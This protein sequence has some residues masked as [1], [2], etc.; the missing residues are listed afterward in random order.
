MPS[1]PGGKSGN[2][3][4]EL[5]QLDYRVLALCEYNLRNA[6]CCEENFEKKHVLYTLISYTKMLH[7]FGTGRPT[8]PIA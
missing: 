8:N 6:M 3:G 7:V 1:V 4:R 5:R 2:W